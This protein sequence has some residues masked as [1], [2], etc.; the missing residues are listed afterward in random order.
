MSS[1]KGGSKNGGYSISGTLSE[2]ED[3][4]VYNLRQRD[5][6]PTERQPAQS[7]LKRLQ[8]TLK[9]LQEK[10]SPTKNIKK[11]DGNRM[12]RR[13]SMFT[14]ESPPPVK[15]P[16][17]RTSTCSDTPPRSLRERLRTKVKVKVSSPQKAWEKPKALL[18]SSNR[19]QEGS[20]QSANQRLAQLRASLRQQQ[21]AK[22]SNN[23]NKSTA[24]VQETR[25]QT[26]N[27]VNV[28][29]LSGISAVNDSTAC[30]AE[31]ES[32]D[33]E[34]SIEETQIEPPNQKKPNGNEANEISDILFMRQASGEEEL[35]TRLL[36][37]T[38]FVLDTNI[39][40]HNIKFVEALTEVILP[41]TVG[42][43]L[44][45]PYVV[46]KELDKLKISSENKRVQFARQAIRYL[47]TKFDESLQ[48]QAQSALEAAE[49]L[50]DVDSPDDSIINCCL[51]LKEQVP[52]LMLLTNDNNLRLKGIASDIQVSCR[53]DLLAEYPDEFAFLSG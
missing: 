3:K 53:S 45:I 39:L 29:D 33:W 32:M 14:R 15:L 35:P 50:I 10:E 4:L 34:E 25:T 21:E 46:I 18:D 5:A 6:L 1:G 43:M 12:T 38:Y 48:I 31:P 22:E 28:C 19:L 42:S 26:P 7:R 20:S 52:N 16:T 2:D 8:T 47:N 13:F 27:K 11:S 30:E 23:N 37:H 9:R 40:M 17:R 24:V 41:G 51:Q 49:H 44:Y 36:D